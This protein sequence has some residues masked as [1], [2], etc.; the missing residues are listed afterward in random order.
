MSKGERRPG[1]ESETTQSD[2]AAN[3]K[4]GSSL[5]SGSDT[6]EI[7]PAGL[8]Q[9]L[10]AI[11][12]DE[13][14]TAFIAL[15]GEPH[16]VGGRY[17]HR[18]W[19]ERKFGW[20]RRSARLA[21][22]VLAASLAGDDVY[23]CPYLMQGGQRAKGAS[24]ARR[25]VHAD[26]D[27]PVDLNLVDGLDGW[28]IAS[29]SADHG[30]VYVDLEQ[31]V[32]ASDHEALCRGL[33]TYLGHADA[34][35]CDND[36]LRP[37]GTLNHKPVA[38][39]TGDAAQVAWLARPSGRRW[40]PERLA[41]VLGVQLPSIS[42]RGQLSVT[43]SVAEV[44]VANLP[45]GVRDALSEVSG[46][47]SVDTM[48]VVAAC[49]EAGLTLEQAR[50]AVASRDDLAERLADR[51]DDD[52]L[53]CWSRVAGGHP[54][55]ADAETVHRGQARMA[56]RLAQE[57]GRRLM[58]VHGIGWHVWDGRRWIED[59][60]REATRAVLDV[61]RTALADSIEDKELRNDVRRCETASGL[62]GVLMIAAALETFAVTVADLDPDPYLLNVA[63]GTL[64]LR[65][66]QLRAHDPADRITKVTAAD[67][68]DCATGQLW[69]AF[70]ERVLP[71]TEVRGFLQRYVGVALCGR[72]REHVL[73]ILTGTGRNGKGVFY[74]A[75]A[76]ALGDY[77]STAE[78]DLFMHRENAH[79]TGEMDLL[80]RRWVVVSESDRGRRLAEATV[81]RLTGGDQIK[82]RRMRQDF[83]AFAP[84]HT[85]AL[86]TNHLPK[87]SGDDPALWARLKVIPFS[88]VIPEVEQDPQLPEKLE[89]ETTAILAWAIQGWRDYESLGLSAPSAVQSATDDYHAESDPIQ[90]FLDECCEIGPGYVVRLVSC[91]V[92]GSSGV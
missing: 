11:F 25:R 79:P 57:H 48:K 18:S 63:N 82:A 3:L 33:G 46:D 90:G 68:D 14:G 34:K 77:A 42:A 28:A 29:G 80:G 10:Q 56:Y 70:L 92:A 41:E 76:A 40:P 31:S 55:S 16:A 64:D 61:L 5:D 73:A 8:E 30:H 60:R 22:A 65:T 2:S 67:F 6:A 36:F 59:H 83:V 39:G 43:H 37:P 50:G 44:D 9:Y 12:T 84:S 26:I 7:D 74:G 88:V 89:R 71:D 53:R 13:T 27:G 86:V 81:K 24:V 66:M 62:A 47:R 15:G 72:V 54:G 17:K 78:P 1:A 23:I 32:T 20:P 21:S 69:E 4:P 51:S 52:V 38:F 58:H 35:V 45:L 85:A 87:V 75:V 49:V 19:K 91:G